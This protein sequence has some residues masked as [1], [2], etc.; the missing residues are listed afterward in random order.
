MIELAIVFA[1]VAILCAIFGFR[2]AAGTAASVA[3]ILF[4]IFLILAIVGFFL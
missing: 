2:S 3:K 4:V 1:V